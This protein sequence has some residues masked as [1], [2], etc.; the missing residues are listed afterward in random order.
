MSFE[1]TLKYE[2]MT[3]FTLAGPLHFETVFQGSTGKL[4]IRFHIF[5]S[6]VQ[7]TINLITTILS[8]SSVHPINN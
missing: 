4:L 1:M 3:S 7:A 6:F 8:F 2:N 5:G